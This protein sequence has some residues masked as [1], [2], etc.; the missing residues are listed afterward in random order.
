MLKISQDMNDN[1]CQEWIFGF[2]FKLNSLFLLKFYYNNL[3]A[4]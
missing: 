4:E 2:I 3:F 1:K